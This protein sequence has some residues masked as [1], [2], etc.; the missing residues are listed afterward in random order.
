MLNTYLRVDVNIFAASL[1]WIVFYIATHR[2][3][4]LDPFNRRYFI[5]CRLI[6][7]MLLFEAATCYM[8]G[9]NILWLRLVSNAMHLCLFALPPVLTYY[10]LLF[11]KTLTER[12]DVWEMKTNPLHLIPIALNAILVLLSPLLHLVF[13]IDGEGVYHRGPLFPVSMI[14]AYFYLLTGFLTLMRRR[15]KLL[16]QEF[17]FLLLF[18]LMPMVAGILQGLF[19]G[20]LFM[21][22]ASACALVILYLY[23]Q[24]R[25]VQIDGLTGAWTRNSF[26]HYV[27]QLLKNDSG[28][29]FG[30][31]YV[32]IDDFKAIND[33]CGHVEG[34][35]ALKAFSNIVK[36]ILRRGDAFARMGGDEF[37]I[38]VNVES[39]ENLK[40]IADRIEAA[41]THFN[42]TSGKGYA[43]RCSTGAEMFAQ[44]ASLDVG[45]ILRHVDRLMYHNKRIHKGEVTQEQVG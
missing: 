43:L 28:M 25:M 2:L 27:S 39:E 29:P 7:L 18:S 32:D 37:A 20:P 15:N 6:L 24:E 26:E 45:D 9:R 33:R 41:L 38:L 4:R 16:K 36:P 31:L 30:I 21:W 17:Q 12:A 42:K 23:L 35:E 1:L 8:N 5:S 22:P 40:S 11:T 19:Y 13:F 3:D 34:D 10:W 14:I 44:S